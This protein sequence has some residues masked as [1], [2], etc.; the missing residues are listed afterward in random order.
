VPPGTMSE[1]IVELLRGDRAA[2]AH[3]GGG[4]D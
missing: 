3:V 1:R 2:V 4:S